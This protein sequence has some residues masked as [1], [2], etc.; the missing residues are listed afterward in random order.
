MVTP[1][2]DFDIK[3]AKEMPFFNL[4]DHVWNAVVE[5]CWASN[6]TKDVDAQV[7]YALANRLE[8]HWR[9][10]YA[11]HDMEYAVLDG[12]F[13]GYF[14]SHGNALNESVLTGLALIGAS[15]YQAVFREA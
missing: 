10:S 8:E 13:K 12:G 4:C 15:E 6:S 11:V 3:A 5:A 2:L 14:W 9:I 7:E 1:T